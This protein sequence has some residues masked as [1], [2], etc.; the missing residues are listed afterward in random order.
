MVFNGLNWQ[1]SG[2]VETDLTKG[3]GLVDLATGDKVPY[4]VLYSGNNFLRVRFWA[5]NLPSVGYKSYALRSSNARDPQASAATH[6]ADEHVLENDYYRIVLD[7]ESGAVK[8]VFDKDLHRELV[9]QSSDFHF[10]QYVYVTGADEEP[11][12]LTRYSEILQPPAMQLHPSGQ[13]HIVSV[14]KTPFGTVAHLTSVGLHT[15]KIETEIILFD[16]KK[17]VQFTNRITKEKVFTKEGVYFAFPFQLKDP[18]FLYETQNGYVNPSRDMLPGAGLEWFSVQHWAA[19]KN[20]ELT[21]A[22]VPV[23]AP[24]VSLGDVVRGTF[25]ARF[26]RRKA[27]IF[28]YVMN[29]YWTTNYVAGQGG[30]FIFRYVLVSGR[31]FSPGSLSKFGRDAMTPFETD[32]IF[33]QD[34]VEQKKGILPSAKA[35]FL[36]IDNPNLVMNTWKQAEDGK[37]MILRLLETGGETGH[38][39][40]GFPLMRLRA[41]WQCNAL[42]ECHDSLPISGESLTLNVKPFEIMTLR[43]QTDDVTRGD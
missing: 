34:R 39:R 7:P 24:L 3:L 16:R 35:S 28:S 9:D 29:N 13:G 36:Q 38:A 32:I 37:G 5:E 4:E 20:S 23:D 1:R 27:T 15:P 18:E 10:N 14:R 25:P 31:D 26:G 12:R 2:L 42:E 8:S 19:V 21:A 43:I 30:D 6:S 22:I 41:A 11:N 33:P 40:L 17:E